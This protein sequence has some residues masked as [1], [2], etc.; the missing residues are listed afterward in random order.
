MMKIK[1]MKLRRDDGGL[2]DAGTK[3]DTL[4][5]KYIGQFFLIVSTTSKYPKI[6]YEIIE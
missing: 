6:K 5:L 3:P 1:A 2:V 4:V